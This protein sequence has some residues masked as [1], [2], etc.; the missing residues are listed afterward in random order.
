MN[1]LY[2]EGCGYFKTSETDTNK[3]LDRLMEILTHE[4]FDFVFDKVQLRNEDGEVIDV[5][6]I[7]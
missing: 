1:E 7:L 2:F 4:G 3:A 5:G 6:E